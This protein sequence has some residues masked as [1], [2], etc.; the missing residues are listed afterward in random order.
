MLYFHFIQTFEPN[1]HDTEY[2]VFQG[3][4]CEEHAKAQLAQTMD[5]ML[6]TTLK[7]PMLSDIAYEIEDLRE[8]VGI[9]FGQVQTAIS[10]L[11]AAFKKAL[12]DISRKMTNQFQWSNLITLYNNA[13]RQIEFYSYRFKELPKSFPETM[14]IEGKTLASAVLQADGMQKWLYELNFLF[15]G[16]TGTPL[17]RH[18]PLMLVFMNR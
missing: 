12:D 10:D 5:S 18:S 4:N 6:E 9:S 7:L 17:V 15:I 11:E 13:I 8:Y 1:Y 16:R 2:C 3:E 14:D